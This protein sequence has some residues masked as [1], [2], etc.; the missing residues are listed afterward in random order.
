MSA[1]AVQSLPWSPRRW[2]ITILSL[3]AFQLLLL[4]YFGERSHLLPRALRSHTALHLAVDSLSTRQLTELATT[5]P[6]IF[7]LPS[8]EGFSGSGWLTF[9]EPDYKPEKWTEPPLFFTLDPDELATFAATLPATNLIRSG[10]GTRLLPPAVDLIPVPAL[11]VAEGS[12]LQLEGSLRERRLLKQP[13][14]PAWQA[15][16]LLT[17]ST[18]LELLVGK[19]GRVLTARLLLSSG[20]KAADDYALELAAG[21]SFEPVPPGRDRGS[22]NT[23]GRVI[24]HWQTLPQGPTNSIS[25]AR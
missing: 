7:A 14:L 6:A 15:D 21:A 20:L 25:A 10:A 5:D 18:V 22:E 23:F 8:L 2:T 13:S 4:L 24:L 11:P 1:S 9:H 19:D 16:D 12:A 3:F 17:N